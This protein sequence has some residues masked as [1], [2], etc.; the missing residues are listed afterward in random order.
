MHAQ[1]RETVSPSAR[2]YKILN[3]YCIP[4]RCENFGAQHKVQLNGGPGTRD[5]TE[6]LAWL[7]PIEVVWFRSAPHMRYNSPVLFMTVRL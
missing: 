6:I 1:S 5:D 7:R 4:R 3:K 2:E